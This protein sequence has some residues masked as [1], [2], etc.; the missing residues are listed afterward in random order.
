METIFPENGGFAGFFVVGFR[1]NPDPPHTTQRVGVAVLKRTYNIHPAHNPVSGWIMPAEEALPVFVQ[2]QPDMPEPR[3]RFEHDLAS[4]KPEGDAV[5]LNFLDVIGL[6]R[7]RVNGQTWL[8]RTVSGSDFDMFG[9]ASR[10]EDG[11]NS[12]KNDAGTFSADPNA[13]P[14]EWPMVNPLKNPLPSDFNNRF[15]NGYHRQARIDGDLSTLPYLSP[16]DQIRIQRPGPSNDYAFT[17]GSEV[18]T[19]HYH[20]YRGSDADEERYWRSQNVPMHADTLVIEPEKNRCYIVWRGVWDF[21]AHTDDVYR[22]LVV[23]VE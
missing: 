9:W 8:E 22:S 16:G 15:Y 14:P 18:V 13:Y 3:L 5:V 7:F 1:K 10:N 12:R 4:F 2:D 23:S 11:S 19:A 6:I 20:Y 17:L 21:D